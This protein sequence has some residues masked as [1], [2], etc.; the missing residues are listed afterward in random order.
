H[1][2]LKWINT[3]THHNLHHQKFH[4]NYSLYFNFWDKVM[5]T[6]F[7]DYSEVFE[8]SVGG[9]KKETI[10]VVPSTYLQKS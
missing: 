5:G 9:E 1:P 2:V 4:G 8:N 10:S 7:K 6:N 3:S